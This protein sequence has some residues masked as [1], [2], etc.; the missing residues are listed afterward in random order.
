VRLTVRAQRIWASDVDRPRWRP[1][2]VNVIGGAF[3]RVVLAPGES[4]APG[5][6]SGRTAPQRPVILLVHRRY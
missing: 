1:A 3:S 4:P 5:A 2:A 6:I